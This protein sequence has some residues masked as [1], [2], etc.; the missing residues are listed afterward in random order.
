MPAA[1]SPSLA[2]SEALLNLHRTA[3]RA[4][5]LLL[6]MFYSGGTVLSGH[7]EESDAQTHRLKL[8]VL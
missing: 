8:T 6:G 7:C 2:D 4:M 1:T 3:S 5:K